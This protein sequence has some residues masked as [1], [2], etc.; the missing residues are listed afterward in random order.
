[1]LLDR[2][3]DGGSI[4]AYPG[5]PSVIT[6]VLGSGRKKQEESEG[7]IMIIFEFREMQAGFKDGGRG[8]APR[9]TGEI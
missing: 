2:P 1:M 6:R 4:L 3:F 8:H 5:R 7:D 9:N